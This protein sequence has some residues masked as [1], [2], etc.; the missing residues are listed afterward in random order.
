MNVSVWAHN[1]GAPA[2]GR[3]DV[4]GPSCVKLSNDNI[5]YLLFSKYCIL[6]YN[7]FKRDYLPLFC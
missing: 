6:L 7:K 4:H 2:T 1:V 5:V 3:D